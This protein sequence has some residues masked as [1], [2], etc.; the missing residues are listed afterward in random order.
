MSKYRRVWFLR[1]RLS[2]R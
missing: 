2:S 1:H